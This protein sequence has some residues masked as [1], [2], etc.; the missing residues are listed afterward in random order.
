M[1]VLSR[2]PNEKVLF[3]SLDIAVRVV[4]IKGNAVRLGIEAPPEIAILREELQEPGATLH[5]P[6]A[7]DSRLRGFR[8]SLR[9]RLNAAT[10]GLALL[11]K[12]VTA[13]AIGD[14]E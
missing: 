8:H 6:A 13:G 2:R 7:A 10:I 12:Q 5:P 3:P 4:S 14:M 1:L 9:N 11:R